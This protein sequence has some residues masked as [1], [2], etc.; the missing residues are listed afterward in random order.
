MTKILAFFLIASASTLLA[1]AQDTTYFNHSWQE[2][3]AQNAPYYRTKLKTDSGWQVIDHFRSG[4]I[5]MNG[6]Y[7]DDS[8]HIAQGEFAWFDDKGIPSHRCH[9]LRGKLEGTDTSYYP[10]GRKQV[11]GQNK[12]GDK[13]GDWIAYYPSGKIAGK[14]RFDKG[15]Q[16]STSF[17]Q[18]NGSANKSATVFMKEATYPG[19]QPQYLRFLNKTIR[20]PDSAVIHEIEG[21]VLIQ[22]MV[23]K[24]G[25]I[26]ELTVLD[27][28][29]KYLDEEAL[30]V[31]RLMRDW[32]PAIIGGVPVDT[33]HKQPIVFHL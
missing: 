25:N 15:K 21:T 27:P 11:I 26:S 30:R 5:Q 32:E 16:L 29:D 17:Y 31:M 9:Y 7:I 18:E 33:Y 20:Y 28:V 13:Q 22:F 4:K 6:F 14:A 23:T 8:F 12:A 3:K 2:T 1:N 10:D 24:T 19:G